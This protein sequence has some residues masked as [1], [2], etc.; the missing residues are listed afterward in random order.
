[1]QRL[2]DI[3][4]FGSILVSISKAIR[5]ANKCTRFLYFWV[6]IT[7]LAEV[8]L[9]DIDFLQFFKEFP[10]KNLRKPQKKNNCRFFFTKTNFFNKNIKIIT[11]R[12]NN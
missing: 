9:G 1:M 12:S 6:K 4:I 3:I 7:L 10:L 11:R 2:C 5:P 8:Y